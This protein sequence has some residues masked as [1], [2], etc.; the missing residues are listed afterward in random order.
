MRRPLGCF[1]MRPPASRA[2][3]AGVSAPRAERVPGFPQTA[4]MQ[5]WKPWRGAACLAALFLWVAVTHAAPRPA[6]VDLQVLVMSDGQA[7]DQLSVTYAGSVAEAQARQDLQSLAARLNRQP[8][9][10]RISTKRINPRAPAMTS[11]EARLPEL[12]NRAEGTLAVQPFIETYRRFSH[13]RLS[14]FIQPPFKLVSPA[15]PLN[16][17]DVQM[18]VD[19]QGSLVNYDLLI[20][21]ANGDAAR[22]PAPDGA[23]RWA[24]LV[25]PA[26]FLALVVVVAIGLAVFVLVRRHG[27]ERASTG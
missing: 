5:R 26:L 15:K 19:N 3:T 17:D 6:P 12:V 2:S 11:V 4:M 13:M 22:I 9:E 24:R 27:A 1:F 23:G 10:V 25:G 21:H 14:Y 7:A 20:R 16:R 18:T 8:A